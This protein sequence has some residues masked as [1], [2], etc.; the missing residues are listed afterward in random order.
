MTHLI[1]LINQAPLI[2][3]QKCLSR[4][5]RRRARFPWLQ[6]PVLISNKSSKAEGKVD[7][8]INKG[9]YQVAKIQCQVSFRNPARVNVPENCSKNPDELIR[10][11]IRT[12]WG[13]VPIDSVLTSKSWVYCS[14]GRLLR[15]G[16]R[17]WCHCRSDDTDA[18]LIIISCLCTFL[19]ETQFPQ[20]FVPEW[21]GLQMKPVFTFPM[22]KP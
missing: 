8:L 1:A 4:S 21:S 6:A 18:Q 14:K 5:R 17:P 10:R 13:N 11:R 15:L 3:S 7:F 16:G 20:S 9:E 22:I 19:P 2:L 12:E